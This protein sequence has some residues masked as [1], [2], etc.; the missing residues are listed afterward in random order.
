[1]NY[2]A[3]LVVSFGG[4]ESPEDV[5]P[6]L[7][8]VLRGRNVPRERMLTVAEHYYHFG[9][10]SPINQQAR[11]LIAALETELAQHGPKLPVYWGNRN[12]HPLL[13][14][15][16]VQMKKDGVRRALAFVTSAYSSYS[17]CRQYREDVARAQ[18]E[19]GEGAPEVDKLRV[20]FNH[21][22]FVDATAERVAEALA[23]V[24]AEAKGNVQVVYIAH[25]IP[26]S[27][28]AT[29]DYVRQLEEVRRLVS[30]KLGIRNH[31]LVY[32]SRSGAPGQPWL[33]PD[34]LDYLRTV[35]TNNLASAVV[36]APISFISDH[37][38]VLYDLDVEARQLCDSLPLPMTRAKTVGVHPKFIAA[39]RELIVER[40]NPGSERRSLGN[41]GPRADVCTEDCCPTPQRPARPAA[42]GCRA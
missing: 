29:S 23:A 34:I 37:M 25:S 8:N 41:L 33:E 19:V 10:K 7:E 12:W 4:P 39:I 17:G 14:E 13:G 11:E 20:F 24:P 31:A 35:R 2:D 30:Q 18:R 22:G 16:L 32:Q 6:F 26:V 1:M 21:P 38:E 5:I 15:T 9:G 27:M 40:M 28:A 36:L 42:S 3:I